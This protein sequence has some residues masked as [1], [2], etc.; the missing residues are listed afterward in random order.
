[1]LCQGPQTSHRFGGAVN[2]LVFL[3]L[4]LACIWSCYSRTNLF[5]ARKCDITVNLPLLHSVPWRYIQHR[6][7]GWNLVWLHIRSGLASMVPFWMH[8]LYIPLGMALW[9]PVSRKW[10][11]Y[12]PVLLPR[13]TVSMP[14]LRECVFCAFVATCLVEALVMI[15]SCRV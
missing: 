12:F 11:Q 14:L 1:M 2:W 9:V 7:T 8:C 5:H 4:F 15:T 6:L 10:G 3:R 13:I